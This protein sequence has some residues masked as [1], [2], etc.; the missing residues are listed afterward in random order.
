MRLGVSQIG[1]PNRVF[2]W[3][4]ILCLGIP[5]LGQAER[6]QRKGWDFAGI[7]LVNFT[8]D[9]GLGYGAYLAGFYHGESG[10]GAAPYKAS[11]GGQFYQTTGGYAFHKLL[12]DFPDIA[13]S[14][15][16]FDLTSGFEAWDNAWY[17]GLG[18]KRPRVR[19]EDAPAHFY[20]S[21]LKS[22]WLVPNVR[23]PI[24]HPWSF[25][26]GLI[27]RASDVGTYPDSLLAT[28][29]PEGT[30]GG[31]LNQLQIGLM[32]DSRDREPST[33]NGVF[34][35]L[36]VRGAHHLTGSDFN[37][38]GVNTTHRQW[39]ELNDHGR[40]ILAMRFGLDHQDGDIPFFHQHILGGSQWVEF[41]GNLTLRG[42][43]NGRY[44]GHTTA[45]SNLELRWT[46]TE[47]K[48]FGSD[49]A[50]LSV[51]F[52]D[53]GRVWLREEQT[54][55]FHIHTSVGHGF[56]GVYNDV[57]VMRFDMAW[58]REEYTRD[59]A[60]QSVDERA[61]VLGVYAIVNHPF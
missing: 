47:F 54:D 16:R 29:Q 58:G 46:F 57:F 33:R 28:E 19:E 42:L 40:L 50:L 14:G 34:T 24:S 53:M 39:V 43:P 35:E 45:Y 61:W 9:R 44:R 26:T 55:P 30:Q 27:F 7:P 22:L 12:L 6:N 5:S 15:V 25:F 21:R 56:R 37:V 36:S 31:I 51:P 52:A 20:T 59:P 49:I 60:Y 41:G 8:T 13:D 10:A 2:L 38:W 3:S 18:N 4:L 32:Y 23:W 48:L 11:I 17:F 1:F